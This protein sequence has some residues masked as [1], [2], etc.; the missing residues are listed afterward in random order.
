MASTRTYFLPGVFADT[1]LTAIPASPVTGVAYRDDT[2]GN[3]EFITGWEFNTIVEGPE[4]NQ[5]LYTH[6]KIIDE[7][8]KQGLL[9]WTD[10][11]DYGVSALVRGSD[12]E[13]YYSTAVNGPA[14]SVQDPVG[15]VSGTW[16]ASGVKASSVPDASTTVKGILELA[17]Q[18]E[19]NNGTDNTRAVTPLTLANATSIGGALTLLATATASASSSI[20]FI[21][22]DD[23]YDEYEVHCIGG[24]VSVDGAQIRFRVSDD[25]GVS[26]KAGASDYEWVGIGN[27][28]FGAGVGGASSLNDTGIRLA[29][30]SGVG[31]AVNELFNSKITVYSPANVALPT[32][33]GAHFIE[34]NITLS[35]TQSFI[36]GKYKTPS[37]I[38]AFRVFPTSGTI[39]SGEFKLYGVKK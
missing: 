31:N 15:D 28:A 36:S 22:I 6:A 34:D 33:L 12:D 11:V 32:G 2:I 18:T 9:G 13:F 1:A 27:D 16:L 14:T 24:K 10:L 3:A 38:D 30:G 4:F 35:T 21:N 8:D 37:V 20:D 39:L 17:T 19:V 25:N 7:V 23:T 29:S 5:I 26:F